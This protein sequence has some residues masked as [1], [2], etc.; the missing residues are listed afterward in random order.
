MSHFSSHLKVRFPDVDGAGIVYYPRFFDFCHQAFED[1]F[2]QKGP[3]SYSELISKQRLGF[4]TVSI[5]SAYHK[6]LF[7]GDW[8]R[9]L[10]TLE[11]IG[12]S[13]LRTAYTI[14]CSNK[15]GLLCFEATITTVWTDLH[16]YKSVP[17]SPPVRQFL[18]QVRDAKQ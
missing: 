7:Y 6:P 16:L 5:Q 14:H 13:S 8:A 3:Y 9:V 11:H 17:I 18:Q 15:E 12:T 2:D 10:G 4:P 1:L